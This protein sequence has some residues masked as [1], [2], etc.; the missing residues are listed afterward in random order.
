MRNRACK[1]SLEVLDHITQ[2]RGRS[3]AIDEFTWRG[4]FESWAVEGNKIEVAQHAELVLLAIQDLL[5][6]VGLKFVLL[7]K[8]R[9]LPRAEPKVQ[10]GKSRKL[11]EWQIDQLKHTQSKHLPIETHLQQP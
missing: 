4:H 10:I 5:K 1:D 3:L 8:L 6:E 2:P 11:G 7:D 9:I